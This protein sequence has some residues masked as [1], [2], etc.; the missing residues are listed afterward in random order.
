MKR[1]YE[2]FKE[3]DNS[4]KRNK[5]ELFKDVLLKV[6][7][8]YYLLDYSYVTDKNRKREVVFARQI[9]MHLLLKNTKWTLGKV[10]ENFNRD[11]AT[12]LHS[13]RVVK[14]LM[15]Y[16]KRIK[17]DVA[18]IEKLTNQELGI[19]LKKEKANS[20]FHYIDLDNYTSVRVTNKKGIIFSGYT[21]HEI[22][23]ILTTLE[24]GDVDTFDHKKTGS[25]ILERINNNDGNTRNT[26]S[27]DS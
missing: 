15:S 19:I 8:D 26:T 7:G 24:I 13:D 23:Q 1:N 22:F 4:E 2:L 25:Y 3:M 9:A 27:I 20:R 6:I 5:E 21:E 12:V 17:T 10:G 18:K 16:H 11:H 14:D